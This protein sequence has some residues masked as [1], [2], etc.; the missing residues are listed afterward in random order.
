MI[1]EDDFHEAYKKWN[2]M[3]A[4]PKALDKLVNEKIEEVRMRLTLDSVSV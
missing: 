1:S 3:D 2:Q 4:D